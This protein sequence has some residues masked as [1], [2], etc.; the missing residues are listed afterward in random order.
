M[1]LSVMLGPGH[2]ANLVH[3]E[4]DDLQNMPSLLAVV[5]GSL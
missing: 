5:P 4:A 2:G 3:N 1:A